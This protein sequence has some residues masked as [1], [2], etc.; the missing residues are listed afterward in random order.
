MFNILMEGAIELQKTYCILVIFIFFYGFVLAASA[1]TSANETVGTELSAGTETSAPQEDIKLFVWRIHKSGKE[2]LT[3]YLVGT[4]HVGTQPGSGYYIEVPPRVIELL[5]SCK[6]VVVEA[7]T[8]ETLASWDIQNRFMF[9]EG[10]TLDTQVSEYTWNKLKEGAARYGITEQELKFVKPWYLQGKV[11]KLQLGQPKE[12]MDFYFVRIAREN[13]MEAY[14]LEGID[15]SLDSI[16][17]V[18]I[19]EQVS[20]L[21]SMMENPGKENEK[22]RKGHSAYRSMDLAGLEEFALDKEDMELFPES[23]FELFERRNNDWLTKIEEYLASE[24]CFIAVGCGHM[25]GEKGLINM[26]RADGYIIEPM[27]KEKK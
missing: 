15:Q 22:L 4:L 24:K 27:F 17:R 8:S 12:I 1:A 11:S 25:L 26:L 5:K 23:Y 19:E 18:P 14:A 7:D 13:D 9:D 21:L 10:S 20:R 16:T 2:A 3:S 6:S